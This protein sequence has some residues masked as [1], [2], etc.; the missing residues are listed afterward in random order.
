MSAHHDHFNVRT[1]RFQLMQSMQSSASGQLEIEEGHVNVLQ[2][3][4]AQR[5]LG[6]FGSAGAVSQ[7]RRDFA[8]SV[9]HRAL[10]VHDQKVEQVRNVKRARSGNSKSARS[11]GSSHEKAPLLG[12]EEVD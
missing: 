3:D 8:A 6:G 9:T 5:L 12:L 1:P 11:S 2:L 10:I 4:H 7:C